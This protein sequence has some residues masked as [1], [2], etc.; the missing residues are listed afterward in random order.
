MKKRNYL[1]R[2]H[3]TNRCMGGTNHP[4]NLV[5]VWWNKHQAWHTLFKNL[6]LEEAI[7]LLI[8][9]KQFKDQQGRREKIVEDFS[10]N[11]PKYSRQRAKEETR[12]I[13]RMY[14]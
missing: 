8:R 13:L 4:C 5:R 12:K 1:T 9:L 6:S 11:A 14:S 2:H 7:A 3:L 10:M